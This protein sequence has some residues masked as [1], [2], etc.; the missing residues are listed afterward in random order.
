VV[1]LYRE[2][3]ATH[4]WVDTLKVPVQLLSIDEYRS[5]FIAAGFANVRDQRIRDPRPVP[6]DYTG[7][8]FKSR[9]DF[10]SYRREGSLMMSGQ[11][12]K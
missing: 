12:A 7:G 2:S 1:D 6:D 4:Q 9:E 8:S 10:E 5:L 11:A 3:P